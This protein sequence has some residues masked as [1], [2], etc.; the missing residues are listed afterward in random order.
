MSPFLDSYEVSNPIF[1]VTCNP[2]DTNRGSGGSSG[3]E[4]ALIA[5]RGSILGIGSDIGGSIRNPSFF[6]G[7]CGFKPTTNRHR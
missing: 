6:T 2:H 1:G 7:L 4:S 5:S 3:G